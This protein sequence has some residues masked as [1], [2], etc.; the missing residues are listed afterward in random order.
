[1]FER[2]QQ[3]I[4]EAYDRFDREDKEFVTLK[5]FVKQTR[6]TMYSD[7]LQEKELES[8]E[9]IHKIA[10]ELD[11]VHYEHT[12][13]IELTTQL[14]NTAIAT[15]QESLYYTGVQSF[16]FEK[17]ILATILAK[18]L[19]PEV[20]KGITRPFL[21]IEQNPNWSLLSVLTDQN[22]IEERREKVAYRFLEAEKDPAQ[23]E[24]RQWLGEKYG[25]LTKEL[26]KA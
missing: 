25:D 18:P 1:T 8:Y 26:V 5:E 7:N 12:R 4:E 17:D 22:I 3:L 15:A 11:E 10:N 21:K 16:N 13:L 2:Y 23:E 19:S 6:D 24:Y 14:R 9:L 20:T